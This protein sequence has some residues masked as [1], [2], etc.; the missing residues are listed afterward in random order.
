MKWNGKA[1]KWIVTNKE[2]RQMIEDIN[3]TKSRAIR[4]QLKDLL[5][6][7]ELK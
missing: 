7:T 5:D 4:K 1:K 2:Y 3:S 6:R